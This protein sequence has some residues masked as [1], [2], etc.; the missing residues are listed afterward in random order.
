[1]HARRNASRPV[2][3]SAD[4]ASG[5]G[6]YKAS[7]H[8]SPGRFCGGLVAKEK[9]S[10]SSRVCKYASGCNFR[11]STGS[12]V[13][14]TEGAGDPEVGESSRFTASDSA[15]FGLS[16][17]TV[18]EFSAS[19]VS[20]GGS[21]EVGEVGEDGAVSEVEF[22]ASIVCFFTAFCCLSYKNPIE[23]AWNN[24]ERIECA[25]TKERTL[26]LKNKTVFLHLSFPIKFLLSPSN[27]RTFNLR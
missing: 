3:D 16:V 13:R 4:G 25:K 22:S 11:G 21:G 12:G 15:L 7:I 17:V 8:F 10:R 6:G 9:D 20:A 24:K 18:A 2:N 14:G 23:K 1:M 19:V 5:L 27:I 26:F